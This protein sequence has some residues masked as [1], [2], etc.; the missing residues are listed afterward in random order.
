MYIFGCLGFSLFF[1]SIFI[2]FSPLFFSLC[3]LCLSFLLSCI[4]C[5]LISINLLL[6]KK[7]ILPRLT[8]FQLRTNKSPFLKSY[9]H[10]GDAKSH[11][12]HY[13]PSVTHT[14]TTHI[15]IS[16]TAPTYAPHCH[17]WICRHSI[18]CRSDCTADWW[19]TSGKIRLPPLARV[20]GVG[21]QQQ[22]RKMEYKPMIYIYI[23]VASLQNSPLVGNFCFAFYCAIL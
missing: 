2:Y 15:I 8:L 14:P 11:L 7:E 4:Y 6:Q 3:S 13:A 1:P 9:L 20:M 17:P 22:H 18:P 12:Y 19:T 21:R 10:K 23:Y 5:L 16:S